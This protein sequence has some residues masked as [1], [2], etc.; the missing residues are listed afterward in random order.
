[1]G[2]LRGDT[3]GNGDGGVYEGACDKKPAEMLN[4]TSEEGKFV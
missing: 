3:V 4:V 1:V 2:E